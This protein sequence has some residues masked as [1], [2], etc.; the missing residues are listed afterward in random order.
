[1]FKCKDAAGKLTYS[2]EE[3]GKIGLD[4][5]GA[6]KERVIVQETRKPKPL[7]P[8]QRDLAYPPEPEAD[9]PK[10]K[11]FFVQTPWGTSRRCMDVHEAD[12]V[13]D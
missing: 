6:V 11:C 4:A 1:M 10:Q 13:P 5:A 3:C 7:P 12:K 2:S 9:K 8:M